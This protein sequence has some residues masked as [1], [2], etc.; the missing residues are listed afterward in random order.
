MTYETKV[1]L[2]LLAD[3]IFHAEDLR[4]AYEAVVW[5]ANAEGV[6]LPSYEELKNRNMAR[7]K[8]DGI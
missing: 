4:D 3:R 1:I 2:R 5:A 6:D 8:Q 7:R